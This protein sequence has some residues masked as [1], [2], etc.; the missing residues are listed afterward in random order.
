MQATAS[1]V[2]QR[3]E[4]MIRPHLRF[5]KEEESLTADQNLGE[6]GLD[7][8][9]S[10]NLLVEIEGEFDIMIPDEDLD[11]NTFTTLANLAQLVENR[12]ALEA[13]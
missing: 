6:A 7:S 5:L 9:A 8:L 12:V 3:L 4:A 11:E 1:G 13:A 10:I 2:T